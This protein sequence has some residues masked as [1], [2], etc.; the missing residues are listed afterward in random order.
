MDAEGGQAAQF[1]A[2]A[3]AMQ[4]LPLPVQLIA[5]ATRYLAAAHSLSPHIAHRPSRDSTEEEA[6]H[7]DYVSAY[8]RYVGASLTC[9]R[10][11]VDGGKE[12]VSGSQLEAHDARFELR[13]RAML[14]EILVRETKDVAEAELHITKGVCLA[15]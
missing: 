14:A 2:E 13:A 1:Y 5:L 6:A 12:A 9:C 4:D 8:R 15:R 11:V 10:A 3:A 7:A